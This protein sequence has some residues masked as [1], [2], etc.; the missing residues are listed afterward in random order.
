MSTKFFK[1]ISPPMAGMTLFAL[2][3]ASWSSLAIAQLP[4][5][6]PKQLQQAPVSNSTPFQTADIL[7]GGDRTQDLSLRD[8]DTIFIPSVTA[9]N[10][11]QTL[12]LSTVSF[13][14]APNRVRRTN[15]VELIGLN[16]NGAI[17]REN[18]SVD[19]APWANT[20]NNP[21]L[22]DND[23]VVVSRSNTARVADAVNLYLSPGAGIITLFSILGI[24]EL[25]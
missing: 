16:P 3:D 20:G 9:V 13:A 8:G 7:G 5:L 12:Q 1:A 18:V 10:L 22:H 2:M 25:E 17:S 24:T 4:T 19:F 15:N 21:I 14:A 6:A 23:I 11:T